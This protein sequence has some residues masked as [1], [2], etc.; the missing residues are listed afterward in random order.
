MTNKLFSSMIILC[1]AV[2]V[3]GC[4]PPGNNVRSQSNKQGLSSQKKSHG[5]A[6]RDGEDQ[7]EESEF[8]DEEYGIEPEGAVTKSGDRERDANTDERFFQKGMAS[9]YGR[10]FNGKATASGERFDMNSLTAAHR[11]LPFGSLLEVKN[12]DNGKSV[13]VTVNDRGPYRGN[14]ILD[15]SY[16]AARKL[17][18]VRSGQ[19]M[20][21]I[22]VLRRGTGETA[23]ASEDDGVEPV[24]DDISRE[25]ERGGNYS[26][27]VGAFYSR[28]NAEELQKR[29]EGITNRDV[30]L[31]NDGDMYKV[32][33]K[34]LG[35]RNE[36]N[37]LKR[38]LSGDDIPS[39]IME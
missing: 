7:V 14:R 26:L 23:R 11:T 34:G 32:R 24:S 27:Q 6:Y 33:I 16:K 25:R 2:A 21:G 35:S 31:F 30:T 12:L 10:E 13:R 36:A 15:L 38:A 29:V 17:E 28:R 5:D 20:V 39:Y 4:T 8:D 9:W 18:M 1:A 19:A 3:I 22:T 37:R